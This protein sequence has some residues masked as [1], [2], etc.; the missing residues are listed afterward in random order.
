MK[1]FNYDD[2]ILMLID[3]GELKDSEFIPIKKPGH[4]ECCTCQQCGYFHDE[5][6][7]NHNIFL[8][9]LNDKSFEIEDK[10]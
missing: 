3:M 1:V 10:K 4:G 6:V 8:K 2:I 9:W 7:C 5:C